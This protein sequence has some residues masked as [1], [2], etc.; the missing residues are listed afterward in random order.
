[1]PFDPRSLLLF[2]CNALLLFL[3]LLINSSLASV[4]VQLFLLGPM[5]IIPALYLR[6]PSCLLTILI[7]GLWVDAA[8]PSSFG[9]FTFSFLAIGS[10]FY[11]IR[12]RFRAEQNFHPILLAHLANA[13]CLLFLTL[14]H[15]HTF[16][17][18][19]PFWIQ[20][21]KTAFLSHLILF[22]VAP[23]FYNLE[24]LLFELCRLDTEPEDLP[25]T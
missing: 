21:G 6:Y 5:I 25:I 24:R 7:S 15:S 1:M 23:W 20:L 8:L 17:N 13:L 2:A 16:L 11:S 18:Q 10:C 9:L 4:N 19:M 12:Y 14:W 3:V 22:L